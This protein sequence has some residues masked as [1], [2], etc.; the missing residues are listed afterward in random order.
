MHSRENW[1]KEISSKFEKGKINSSKYRQGVT[2]LFKESIISL[3]GQQMCGFYTT[4][5]GKLNQNVGKVPQSFI[6]WCPVSSLT[7]LTSL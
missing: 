2:E 1:L 5:E 7:L 4:N 3:T 6:N